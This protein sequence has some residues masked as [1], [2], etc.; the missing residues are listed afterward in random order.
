M[1]RVR[2]TVSL[3]ESSFRSFLLFPKPLRVLF[4]RSRAKFPFAFRVSR[5]D[6]LRSN[7]QKSNA[8]ISSSFESCI[9][10]R[11]SVIFDRLMI[12]SFFSDARSK[13]QSVDDENDGGNLQLVQGDQEAA[14]IDALQAFG[15][16]ATD[17]KKAKE[18]GFNTVRS[19][20]MYSKSALLEVRGFSDA[21]VEK[22]LEACK[23]V[24]ILQIRLSF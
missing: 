12:D 16:S 18:A 10:A 2:F 11:V 20:V 23:K 15:V 22:L 17:L 1:R 19:L 14:S 8:L 7:S 6:K 3:S 5:D 13:K 9:R 4:F 21:K 24:R